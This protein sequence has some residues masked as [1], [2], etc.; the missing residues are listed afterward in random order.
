MSADWF[1]LSRRRNEHWLPELRTEDVYDVIDELKGWAQPLTSVKVEARDL[2]GEIVHE[3][4]DLRSYLVASVRRQTPERTE[5]YAITAGAWFRI[6]QQYVEVVDRHLRD[7]VDD[8]T[9]DLQLPVWDDKY[10]KDNVKGKYGEERYNRYVSDEYGYA[11]LDRKLYRGQAGE[12][13]EICDLLTPDK[14]LICVKRM[15]GSDKLS[16]L[17]QQGS[18]SAQML[19]TNDDYKA[20]VMDKLRELD[21]AAEFG[22][23]TEW[24]VVY[25]IA[26]SKPGALKDIMYF[27]S[28]AALRMRGL[29]IKGNDIRVAVAKIDRLLSERPWHLNWCRTR[30]T[31]SAPGA[32]TC[33]SGNFMPSLAYL[34]APSLWNES[35][36]TRSTVLSVLTNEATP[37]TLAGSSVSPGT[38]TNR[39]HIGLPRSE[40]RRANSRVGATSPPV[41]RRYSA[42]SH[43]LMSS[44]TKSVSSSMASVARAPR[45]PDVSTAVCRPRD[46]TSCSSSPAKA[47]C[48]SGSP[49]LTVKPPPATSMNRLYLVTS[50]TTSDTVIR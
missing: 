39:I 12:R 7:N 2:A 37:S 38:R 27:F 48:S 41:T 4:V 40:R 49:P 50:A 16:H 45:N 19:M 18:V 13:V 14:K 34:G 42:G 15:D 11:L 31:N 22:S 24:T 33:L 20:K 25:A 10:L 29:S 3:R 8:L 36:S 1:R 46:F 21:P 5:D 26:T 9:V 28:R 32:G 35:T 47:G 17:F 43:D 44:N 6:D 30:S 23:P